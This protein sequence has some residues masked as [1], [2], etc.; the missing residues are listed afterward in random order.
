MQVEYRSLAIVPRRTANIVP[1][2]P[3][4]LTL[5]PV[6]RNWISRSRMALKL[7]QSPGAR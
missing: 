5:A 7:C 1:R 2:F 3:G 6:T 4:V